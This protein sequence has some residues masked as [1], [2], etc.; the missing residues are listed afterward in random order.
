MCTP[1]V[2][3]GSYYNIHYNIN[4]CWVVFFNKFNGCY[5]RTL[6]KVID[7]LCPPVHVSYLPFRSFM[8]SLYFFSF[9]PFLLWW[10][11]DTTCKRP[12]NTNHIVFTLIYTGRL[13]HFSPK[14][15]K[16]YINIFRWKS[17][18]FYYH[19]FYCLFNLIIV[20]ILL[21]ILLKMFLKDIFKMILFLL[22]KVVQIVS[23]K[24][25]TT[26]INPFMFL[27]VWV[28]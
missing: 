24:T 11:N 21:I 18:Y 2:L 7:S 6:R 16:D 15:E 9:L 12:R 27:Q 10:Y 23:I 5:R 19:Q 8:S 28:W 25:K 14:T 26:S 3:W 20:Y 13:L 22:S 1:R 17:Y 4:I